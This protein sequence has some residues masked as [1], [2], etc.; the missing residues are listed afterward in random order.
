[1]EKPHPIS[2]TQI[3]FTR[4]VVLSIPGHQPKEGR[5]LKSLPE[6]TINLQAVEDSPNHYMV[7]MR[8]T[9]NKESDTVDPYF[10]DMECVGLFTASPDLEENEAKRGVTITAH[11][12]LYGAI[13]EAILWLTGRQPYGPLTLGLSILK[14][15]KQNEAPPPAQ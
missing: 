2:L 11:S 8:T 12:V 6:N 7:T 4:S 1:M 13:R 9:I 5:G 3:F 14:Q 15:Q 10:I